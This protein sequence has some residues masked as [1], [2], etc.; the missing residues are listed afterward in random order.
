M[1]GGGGEGKRY[2]EWILQAIVNADMAVHMHF[3]ALLCALWGCCLKDGVS[4]ICEIVLSYFQDQ[5]TRSWVA[6]IL[7]LRYYCELWNRSHLK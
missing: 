6:K 7:K 2:N 3:Y 1:A 5:N 4:F